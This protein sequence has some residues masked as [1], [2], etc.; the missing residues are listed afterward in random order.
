M[1]NH[2]GAE[3]T[4]QDRWA[5]AHRMIGK[6]FDAAVVNESGMGLREQSLGGKLH[7]VASEGIGVTAN[8]FV[9]FLELRMQS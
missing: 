5:S 7:K 8:V 2:I 3:E 4:H 1:H 9:R 6:L